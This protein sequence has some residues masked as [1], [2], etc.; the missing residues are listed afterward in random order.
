ME[1]V[2]RKTAY[3]VK[4]NYFEKMRKYKREK[5]VVI[6]LKAKSENPLNFHFNLKKKIS[7]FNPLQH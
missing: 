1:Y 7:I 6:I 4:I 2:R 5:N 3:I